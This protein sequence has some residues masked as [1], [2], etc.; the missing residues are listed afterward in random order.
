MDETTRQE[1]L[2]LEAAFLD[3]ETR[4]NP[5]WLDRTLAPDVVEFGRSGRVYDKAALIAAL[6]AEAPSPV[7][8]VEIVTPAVTGLGPDAALVTYRLEPLVEDA[9][10]SLRSSVWTRGA[11]GWR[12]LFHQGTA[13]DP[14]GGG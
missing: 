1:L 11:A 3:G 5:G 6:I 7:P 14:A 13:A 4:H 10:P 12:L 2:A 9:A 8:R